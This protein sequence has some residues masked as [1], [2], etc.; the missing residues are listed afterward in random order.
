MDRCADKWTDVKHNVHL[1]W[2]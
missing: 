2:R 1:W